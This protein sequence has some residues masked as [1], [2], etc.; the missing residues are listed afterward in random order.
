MIHMQPNTWSLAL[1]PRLDMVEFVLPNEKTCFFGWQTMNFPENHDF[2]ICA[3]THKHIESK[4]TPTFI[5]NDNLAVSAARARACGVQ[6][7][8]GYHRMNRHERMQT[9]LGQCANRICKQC[10]YKCAHCNVRL[11]ARCAYFE[12]DVLHI[13]EWQPILDR[14]LCLQC[15]HAGHGGVASSWTNNCSLPEKCYQPSQQYVAS[16]PVQKNPSA[17]LLKF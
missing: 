11:C 7:A 12:E 14:S 16:W 13:N 2:E 3:I 10:T 15:V 5:P 8:S 17:R 6:P 9:C 4:K 1:K